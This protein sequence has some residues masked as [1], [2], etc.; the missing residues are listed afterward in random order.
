MRVS[1]RKLYIFYRA[2]SIWCI[3]TMWNFVKGGKSC[4]QKN[5]ACTHIVMILVAK[6]VMLGSKL[7]FDL[8][9]LQV[10]QEP[11]TW[12][13]AFWHHIA[14]SQDVQIMLQWMLMWIW[15]N[16]VSW[17]NCV[18]HGFIIRLS[19]SRLIGKKYNMATWNAKLPWKTL[20]FKLLF[21][22]DSNW[23]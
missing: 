14:L 6:T 11:E 13:L 16:K 23:G 7:A 17:Q 4:T 1:H 22:K 8:Q 18:T 20:N 5:V 15:I 2:P 21:L 9:K 3:F 12:W 19:A 10:K